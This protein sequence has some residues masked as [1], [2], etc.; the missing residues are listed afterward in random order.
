M[1]HVVITERGA[2]SELTEATDTVTDMMF[3]K[4]IFSRGIQVQPGIEP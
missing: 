3:T 2:L 4:Y 1:Q